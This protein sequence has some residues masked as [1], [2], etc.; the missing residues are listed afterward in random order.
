MESRFK[1]GD[2]VAAPVCVTNPEKKIARVRYGYD[3]GNVI[4][5]GRNKK[6]GKP[7]IKVRFP[8]ADSIWVKRVTKEPFLEKWCLAQDCDKI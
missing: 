1:I 7:A 3:L 4:A 8:T 2:Q 6:S 5:T